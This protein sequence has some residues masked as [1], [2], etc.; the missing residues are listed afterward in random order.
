MRGQYQHEVIF[1]IDKNKPKIS[2]LESRNIPIAHRYYYLASM[3]RKRYDDC[4]DILENQH[5]VS[6][7]TIIKIITDQTPL[8]KSLV[9]SKTSVSALKKKYPL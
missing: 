8:L 3:L 7:H 4:I 6:G 2:P 5:F 9:A 1:Q